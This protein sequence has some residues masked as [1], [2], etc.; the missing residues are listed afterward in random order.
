MHFNKKQTAF[1]V[2]C[3]CAAA[4]VLVGGLMLSIGKQS[5]KAVE[6]VDSMVASTQG[7]EETGPLKEAA[8]VSI[9]VDFRVWTEINS[10]IYGWITIPDTNI[11][12]PV[13]QSE[14]DDAYYLT[15]HF[16]KTSNSFGSI[17]SEATYNQKNFTDRVTTLYGHDI[18]TDNLYFHQL[19]KFSDNEFF[20]EHQAVYT[21]TENEMQTWNVLAWVVLDDRHIMYEY[22]TF[23]NT[24]DV[25]DF[26]ELV[27]SSQD[28]IIR[29][30]SLQ[31]IRS[32]NQFLFLSTCHP[33]LPDMRCILVCELSAQQ[34]ASYQGEGI[35]PEDVPQ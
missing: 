30:G 22:D 2:V 18:W 20:Q 12:Y 33:E 1:A 32:E 6:S 11:S 28:S 7:E 4:V 35:R 26:F 31:D 13:V 8:S 9:P 14:E 5:Q 34:P 19:H 25:S 27:R 17:F 16:D 21:Y 15:H 3:G 24:E 10:D 29:E 23:A